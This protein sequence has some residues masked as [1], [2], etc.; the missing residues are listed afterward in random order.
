MILCYD[1]ASPR[2]LPNKI[3]A[4][5]SVKGLERA[6][7]LSLQSLTDLALRIVDLDDCG[8]SVADFRHIRFAH[9]A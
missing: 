7:R 8:L 2:D 5:R 3:Y 4:I 9:Y 6:G 1:P